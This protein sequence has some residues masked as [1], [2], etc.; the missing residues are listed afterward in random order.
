MRPVDIALI[1]GIFVLAGAVK[2]LTGM[3][4]PLI[5]IGFLGLLMPPVHAA[6]FVVIPS[7]V[8]NLW[9]FLAGPDRLMLLRR[10][11]W[12]LLAIVITTWACAG[13]IARSRSTFDTML[14]GLALASYALLGLSRVRMRVDRR[15][16]HWLSPVVGA[17]TGVIAG[18]TGVFSIPAVPYLQ[19]LG[20]EKDDLVQALGLS[21][22]TSTV[23]LAMGL[24]S[25]GAFR[26]SD[27]GTSVLCT[28][29]ALAGV[30]AGQALR[31][32]I[33]AATFRRV[34]LTGLLLL[35][36]YL[37]LRAVL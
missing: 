27:V 21:F 29:P 13:V 12:M 14:L 34:F 2:G 31:A 15:H 16:E 22:T 4:L 36:G 37:A 10:M 5:A 23:S 35:G 11:R 6:A 28:V 26:A 20:L 9:Q 25:Y 7:L 8:S 3:G 19:A 17:V 30:L 33:D 1:T 24:A 32:R 18:A